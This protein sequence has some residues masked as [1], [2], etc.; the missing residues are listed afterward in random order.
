MRS[1]LTLKDFLLKHKWSYFI[2]ILWLLVV[3]GVQLIV[4]Q[5]FRRLT[6]DF[7]SG[8]ISTDGIVKYVLLIILTGFIIA[9]GRFG[10]RVYIFGNA[11]KVEYYLRNRIFDKYL[12]LSPNYFNTHKT[13]DLMA[14][15]TNDVN[16]IRM[17]VGQGVMMLVDSTFM[18]ILSLIMMARTTNLQLT[19]L[20]L[21]T[22]PAT[23]LFVRKFGQMIHRRFRHV[24]EAFS[25]L[26]DTIQE[27]FSGIR[28]IKSFVQEDLALDQ[29]RAVNQDNFEKNLD[30]VKISGVFRPFIQFISAISFLLVIFF[31][32][33]QVISNNISLGEF[34]AFNSYLGLIIWPMMA[35]GQVINILQRG[36][37]SMERINRILDEEPEI[38]EVENPVHLEDPKG[39]IEFENVT[40]RYPN[41]NNNALEDINFTLEEGKSLAILGRTGSGKTTIVNLL[42]RL[43]D[44][45]EGTIRYSDVDI[46]DL[47]FKSLREN[48]GYVP[49][50]NFLFSTSIDEN[51]AFAF[52]EEV[53]DEMIIEAAKM[54]EVYD[55]IIEFPKQFDTV[56]GERGVTLS[57]G[58]KQRTSIARALI[59][60]PSVLILDDSLSAVDTKTEERIL[61]NIENIG[62]DTTKIIISHRVSTVQNSDEIIF[63]E[64]GRIAERG[65]HE[66]L[67]EEKGLYY[68]LY[69]KQLLEE[70]ITNY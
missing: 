47:S 9:A 27:N 57:G 18:M 29:F 33:K 19:S 31:G 14:H 17:A 2:G 38:V 56:L 58:Q 51:I 5:I 35:F 21:I 44:I 61:K 10:W 62:R 66:S 67:L 16:A 48:I 60:K 20:V 6:D 26:T 68:E 55:N 54:G 37:A 45:E 69:E 23:I 15:A 40:F 4:P 64:E 30:L 52:D 25:D 8:M 49:Q 43:Y 22:L 65:D 3:D 32:G 42:L 34:I 36:A 12:S 59:K 1:F 41:S 46:R 11:R 28:V 70:K 53:S 13:G 50:D 7:Q 39:K 24:Q 63:L